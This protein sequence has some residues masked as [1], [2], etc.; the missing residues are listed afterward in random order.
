M[1]SINKK[2]NCCGCYACVNVCPK[3]CISMEEDS[4]GF[5][6]PCVD[7]SKCVDCTLC[8]KVCPIINK[9]KVAQGSNEENNTYVAYTKNATVRKNSS[10]GG[11][12]TELAESV[13]KNNGVVF[14]CAFDDDFNAHHI[15][16]NNSSDLEKLRGSKYIQSHIENTYEEA[17]R[18]LKNGQLV[19]F[20][21]VACQIAGLNSYLRKD[22]NNLITVDVL[23]HGVPSGKAW[24]KYIDDNQKRHNAKLNKYYFRNKDNGWKVFTVKQ[25]YMDNQ[26]ESSPFNKDSF[27]QLFLGE[28]CLRPSCHNCRFK[29]IRRPSDIT[30]GDCWGVQNYM[31]EMDD[32]KG[33]SVVIAHT[34]KGV[35]IL[36]SVKNNLVIK[37]AKL[38]RALPPTADSRKSV[39]PHK[40]REIFFK[41]LNE[42]KSVDELAI[43]VKDRFKKP[44]IIK[45]IK[46]KAKKIIKG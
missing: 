29:D 46:R 36:N 1:I 12:F 26:G 18:L 21:G 25:M 17:E 45:R 23:C 9:D 38:D 5:N 7:K 24:R 41:Q 43:L 6:Y 33:T 44:N 27:M 19:L 37:K 22:Y 8:E 42:G 34:K 16:V 35:N 30:L 3:D 2:D 10:S 4:E 40:N 13:L 11:M 20:S 15:M 32:D 31:P 14:G 39:L 28:V